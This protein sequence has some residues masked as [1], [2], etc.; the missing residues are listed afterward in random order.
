MKLYGWPPAKVLIYYCSY[1]LV[2]D[3]QKVSTFADPT[4]NVQTINRER[5]RMLQNLRI[6]RMLQNCMLLV[7]YFLNGLVD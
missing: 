4:E 7:T 3:Y 2:R 1:T 6:E 5:F